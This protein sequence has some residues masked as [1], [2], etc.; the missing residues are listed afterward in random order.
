MFP[1]AR[2]LRGHKLTLNEKYPGMVPECTVSRLDD[3]PAA[4]LA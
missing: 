1:G 3:E 2:C 4:A